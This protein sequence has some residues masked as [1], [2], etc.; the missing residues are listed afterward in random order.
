[1]GQVLVCKRFVNNDEA[2]WGSPPGRIC[3]GDK[4]RDN[5]MADANRRVF[6]FMQGPH[7]PFFASLAARFRDTGA[8]VWRVGFNAGDQAFWRDS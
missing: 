3:R 7:G 8:E 6:L 2:N 1:M 4:V 5:S